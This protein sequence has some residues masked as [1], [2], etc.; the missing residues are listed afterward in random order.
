MALN[1]SKLYILDDQIRDSDLYCA[2]KRELVYTVLKMV[3]RKPRIASRDF[4]QS[5][6]GFLEDS[7]P[8]LKVEKTV[9][10]IL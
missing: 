5:G 10:D 2:G 9:A 4:D 1:G 6:C 3:A 8:V 7:V